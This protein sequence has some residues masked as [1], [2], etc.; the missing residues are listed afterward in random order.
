MFGPEFHSDVTV[1][2]KLTLNC[3]YLAVRLEPHPRLTVLQALHF[4][5]NGTYQDASDP[6]FLE[7]MRASDATG[8]LLLPY[9][10]PQCIPFHGAEEKGNRADVMVTFLADLE[11][12][13][14]LSF[15][16]H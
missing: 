3:Q 10:V 7:E 6:S 5:S 15:T 16:D 11:P 12:D 9:V 8:N 1:L 13:A 4:S 2:R 14:T